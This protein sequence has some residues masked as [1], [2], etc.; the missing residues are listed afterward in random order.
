[1]HAELPE[2]LAV[3]LAEVRDLLR[4]LVVAA[5]SC[6]A[7]CIGLAATHA[8]RLVLRA[9]SGTRAP[10]AG[11]SAQGLPV[12][13]G[14]HEDAILDALELRR[15]EKATP[16]APPFPHDLGGPVVG[17]VLPLPGG[18]VLPYGM[19]PYGHGPPAAHDW[20]AIRGLPARD[21]ARA[22]P[23][24]A[25]AVLPSMQQ[26]VTL[27][28]SEPSAAPSAQLEL[29]IAPEDSVSPSDAGGDDMQRQGT[30]GDVMAV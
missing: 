6:V 3:E 5:F 9:H 16:L 2:A 25:P 18:G 15:R 12:T 23:S 19:V 29:Q 10:A 1:M 21:P 28:A 13:T 17:G 14:S 26:S 27:S 4:L 20:R 11:D 8:V 24:A 7:V 30:H 22:P